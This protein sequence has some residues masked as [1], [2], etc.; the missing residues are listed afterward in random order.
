[1]ADINTVGTPNSASFKGTDYRVKADASITE[2]LRRRT[3]ELIPTS[4]AGMVKAEK[5]IQSLG[6]FPFSLNQR[7]R[8]QL[9]DAA[10]NGPGKFVY[11]DAAGVTISGQAIIAGDSSR[12]SD[13]GT[14]TA[15][16]HFLEKPTIIY[17]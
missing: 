10:D 12:T 7:E 15:D 6:G 5:A 9:D 14:Y 1:M 11:V 4:G 16:I 8:S 17:P 13:E 3:N 2:M